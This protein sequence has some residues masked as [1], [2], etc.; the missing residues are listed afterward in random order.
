MATT[1]NTF[2]GNQLAT[3]TTDEGAAIAYL[4]G[5]PYPGG[6]RAGVNAEWATPE[7]SGQ[8]Q[9]SR[10]ALIQLADITGLDLP[11]LSA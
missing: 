10:A 7:G 4:D 11:F 3:V 9:V 2:T 8:Y 6:T 1:F 5:L